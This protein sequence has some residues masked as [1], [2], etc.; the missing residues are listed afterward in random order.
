MPTLNY[1]P[2]IQ[3]IL[4]LFLHYMSESDAYACV[5]R[6]L[7]H[8]SNYMKGSAL[9]SKAASYTLLTLVKVHKVAVYKALK[10][11]IGSSDENILATALQS[12]P[13]WIFC[14]LPFEHLICIIDCYLYEGNKIL[15]RIPDDLTEKTCQ[16]RIDLFVEKIIQSIRHG[17]ISVTALLVTATRIRN[18]SNTKIARFQEK[19]EKMVNFILLFFCHI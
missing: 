18:F 19:Y 8:H 15:M 16:Q 9:A 10:N 12:W 6:I 13:R 11:W 17:N 1:A 5:V 7:K 2:L 3:P 4:A 14:A